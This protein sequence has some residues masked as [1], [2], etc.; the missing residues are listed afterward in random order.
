MC[1]IFAP[2]LGYSHVGQILDRSPKN[3]R[4]AE[5]FVSRRGFDKINVDRPFAML[6]G[7]WCTACQRSSE[8]KSGEQHVHLCWY[9]VVWIWF[10]IRCCQGFFYIQFISNTGYID[11]GGGIKWV[12][13]Q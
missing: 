5:R 13:R 12:L 6:D 9:G 2:P 7:A 3:K 8:L 1:W 10:S 4:Q 11:G